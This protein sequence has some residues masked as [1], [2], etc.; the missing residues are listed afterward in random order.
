MKV[1]TGIPLSCRE[2][3]WQKRLRDPLTPQQWQTWPPEVLTQAQVSTEGK[4]KGQHSSRE[5]H[6][7]DPLF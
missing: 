5:S 4:K 1:S 3:H 6:G 2:T 7:Q